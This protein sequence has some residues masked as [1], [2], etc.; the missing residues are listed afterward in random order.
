L[1]MNPESDRQLVKMEEKRGDVGVFGIVLGL[2][3]PVEKPEVVAGQ[4]GSVS[5]SCL[6]NTS[7]SNHY[8]YWYRQEGNNRPQF[9]LSRFKI[10]EG[11]NADKEKY[12]STLNH[13]VK[14]VPLR[15]QKLHVTD[16]A[17]YYCALQPTVTGNS[18][19]V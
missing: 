16:S 2:P 17:V 3:T 8:L 1:E 9:I 7:S 11:K 18:K 6:Y 14:S 15:I 12:S 4:G 10:G 13:E 5:L 19:S